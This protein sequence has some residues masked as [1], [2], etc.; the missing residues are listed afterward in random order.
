MS[1]FPARPIA[2]ACCVVA[3]G[4]PAHAAEPSEVERLR[5]TTEHLI[6]LLVDQGVISADKAQALRAQVA[7]APTPAEPAKPAV[8]VPYVPEFVRKEIKDE[9][10]AE[11]RAQAE[12]EG[13]AGPGSVPDWVRDVHIEGDLRLRYQFD[14]YAPD[15]SQVQTNVLATNAARGLRLLRSDDRQRL[16]ARARIELGGKLDDQW[17]TGLRLT[18]GSTTDPLSSNQTLGNYGNRYGVVFDR[19]YLRWRASDEFNVVA[20]RFGNPWFGT[21]LVWANE[22]GFDGVAA[23]WTPRITPALRG[24]TT[25]ALLPVQEVDVSMHDKWLLGAQVGVEA[26][27]LPGQASAK[28]GMG[29][30]RYHNIVGRRS[31]TGLDDLEFTAPQF[32]QKGNTYYDISSDP[33]RP[34]LGLAGDYRLL[35]VTAA[36]DVPAVGANHVIVTGDYVA[37]RGFD[38]AAVQQRIGR[39]VEPETKGYLVRVAVGHPEVKKLGD[40]QM[41]TGYK[42]VE[43]DAVLDAYTDSD[44]RLGGSNAKGF[45]VGGNLGVGRNATLGLR[46]LSA[47]AVSGEQYS[48]DVV[49]LDLN[50]RF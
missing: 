4:L 33:A 43:R 32:A 46:M 9:V 34:L 38:R 37:N 3:L 20:G 17:S 41:V 30:Y 48:V 8:R 1:H 5:A 39:D 40:W 35:N 23:Q 50:L 12:R 24:F 44:F 15:N 14:N 6:Q 29:V 28:L 22:L 10:S 47:D 18:T 42:R 27:R 49:Q 45:F 2:L 21:D 19:A 31:S 11:L 13:W 36:L 25:L 7:P 26:A 16:R